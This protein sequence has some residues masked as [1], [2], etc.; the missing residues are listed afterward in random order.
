MKPGN[1]EPSTDELNQG[2][3]RLFATFQRIIRRN[4]RKLFFWTRTLQR[5][6]QKAALRESWLSRE[7]IV[8]PILILSGT[9]RCNLNCK[10]CYA[11]AQHRPDQELSIERIKSLFAEASELGVGI[12]MMAGGEPLMRPEILWAAG[13]Q[14][15]IIFPV[16]TN[17][18]MLNEA[19]RYFFRE[20]PNVFPVLSA[21]GD[22]KRT[23]QRRGNGIHARLLRN[24]EILKQAGHTFGL[25]FTLTRNNFQE[26]CHPVWMTHHRQLGA[27]L[28]FLVEYVPQSEEEKDL[29]LTAEQK[30]ELPGIVEKL[31]HVQKNPIIALPGDEEKFGGCL[32]GGRGFMHISASGD[33]EPCPFA[34]YSDSNISEMTLKNALKSPFLAVIREKHHLLGEASG[35]CTLWENREWV[36]QTL[37]GTRALTTA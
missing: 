1:R 19:H 11:R 29:C 34:P 9:T 5:Q 28:F 26:I 15:D 13:A 32:A 35:G 27:S 10:G 12:I 20:H 14:K 7:V 30:K 25:S 24:M 17:G 18:T 23:D 4:P 37:D 16:F 3:E 33:L 31:Q 21:E 8:P 36:Q 22:R 6:K 2:I